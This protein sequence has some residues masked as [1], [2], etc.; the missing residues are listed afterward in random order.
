[1]QSSVKDGISF[2]R[3]VFSLTQ[4][5]DNDLYPSLVICKQGQEYKKSKRYAF[6]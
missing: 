3:T 2:N 5:F 6:W 1:M 4:P